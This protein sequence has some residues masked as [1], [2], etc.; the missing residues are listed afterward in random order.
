MKLKKIKVLHVVRKM[1]FGGVER[2]LL[3]VAQALQHSNI[4]IDILVHTNEPGVLDDQLRSVGVNII[5]LLGYKNPIK[6]ISN[7]YKILK[8][9]GPYD[10]VHSHVLYFSGIVLFAAKMAGVGIRISHAHSNRSDIEPKKGLRAMYISAMKLLVKKFANRYIAVSQEAHKSLH[11]GCV[12]DSDLEILYCGI[13]HLS[14]VTINENLKQF[15]G[16]DEK[17]MVLG[18]VGRMSEPKNHKF[19][20]NIFAEL[21][22]RI[23]SVLVLVGDGELK[24]DIITD[25]SR[26]GLNNDVILLGSRDDAVDIMASIFDVIAF[27][28]LYE[29]LPLTVVEAQAVGIPIIVSENITREAEF[30]HKLVH[31]LSLNCHENKWVDAILELSVQDKRGL[32]F[33]KFSSTDFYLPNHIKKLT[34]IYNGNI[35]DSK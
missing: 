14:K 28:S 18:H 32:N 30:D 13:Q 6:Y 24:E 5:P 2:W 22:T 34:R 21:K 33:E 16:I 15:L 17:K 19:L 9:Q 11:K 31:Y 26:L 29:G 25:I 27:P 3:G 4:Q 1:D 12:A 7:L 8:R 10:V 20:L 23:D 35:N